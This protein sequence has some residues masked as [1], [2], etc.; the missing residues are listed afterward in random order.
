MFMFFTPSLIDVI[1]F[2][3]AVVVAAS[4]IVSLLLFASRRRDIGLLY[5]GLGATMYGVRLAL[6]IDRQG[7]GI[8]DLALT[9]LLPVPLVLFLVE[10]VAP[11][12]RKFAW[13]L[14]GVELSIAAFSMTTHLLRPYSNVPSR[15]NNVVVLVLIP[16]W[17][18]M[19]FFP[20]R[21]PSSNMRIIRFGLLVF[22]LFVLYNNLFWL[23]LVPGSGSM[24]P[25]GFSVLLWCLGLVAFGRMQRNEEQ[26]ISLHKE[27]EIARTIQSRLLPQPTLSTGELTIASRY[28]P[29]TSVAGD[30][31]D[32]L[33]HDEGLGILIADVSGHGIPAALS[34]SM[35]KVAVRAQMQN[36]EDPARVLC[37]MNS[38]L[39]GNL[40]GQ[41]VS[42]GYLYLNPGRATMTYA[43]AGHPPLLL[44]HSCSRKA[45][46]L[47]ENGFPLGIFPDGAYHARQLPLAT[48]D[49]CVLY[50]DGLLEA[51]S[52]SGEE[53]GAERL[54]AF[55]AEQ[56]S[57][58]PQPFCD[59]LVARVSEWQGKSQHAHDD[60]TIVVVDFA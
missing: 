43:G 18:I 17:V 1:G 53:F 54:I 25:I 14:V 33:G 40:D 24:E 50:T 32:F 5:F 11:E 4:G 3:V 21:S 57:L 9:L 46:T 45:E 58:A 10:A 28:V 12:W 31:Y 22:L 51:P 27:L 41:F 42:A 29:A 34:A 30:F 59:K 60:L 15:I 47:V 36:A 49:R 20:R 23:R 2:A 19:A 26:L 39:H 35:V 56:A 38:I 6:Q 48:G 37:G 8:A 52:P 16:I 55:V 44:W 13:W 7:G